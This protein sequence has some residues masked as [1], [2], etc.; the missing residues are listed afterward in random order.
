MSK[1]RVTKAQREAKELE[2][3]T[4]RLTDIYSGA[5]GRA[6]DKNM[7]F[8]DAALLATIHPAVRGCFGDPK[9]STPIWETHHLAWWDAPE[10]LAAFLF[11]YGIRA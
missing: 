1:K 2:A 11:A 10:T 9:S 8:V 4:Q 6:W 3:L 5:V 7:D